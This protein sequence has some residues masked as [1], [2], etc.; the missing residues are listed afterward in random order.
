M[1]E[2]NRDGFAKKFG[3][4]IAEASKF[5]CTAEHLRARCDGGKDWPRNIVAACLSCNT[6]R[7]QLKNPP[8]PQEHK[9]SMMGGV[10]VRSN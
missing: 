10:R 7:H 8:S 3:F 6:G 9:K 4:S 2:Q 1:W 5:Q